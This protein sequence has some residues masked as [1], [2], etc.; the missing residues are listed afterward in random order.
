[1]THEVTGTGF[2]KTI[3]VSLGTGLESLVRVSEAGLHLEKWM[4][5]QVT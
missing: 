1:M 2:G 3:S 5:I 4:F